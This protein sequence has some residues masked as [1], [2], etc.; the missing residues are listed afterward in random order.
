MITLGADV[1]LM[2]E[3]SLYGKF[4]EIPEFL[5][6]RRLHAAASSGL[7]AD[8]RGGRVSYAKQGPQRTST[9]EGL[10]ASFWVSPFR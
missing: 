3:L 4:Y 6:Y 2:A 5:F 9:A 7:K 8:G 10:E 1:N